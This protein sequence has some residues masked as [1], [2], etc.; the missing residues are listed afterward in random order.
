MSSKSRK[1]R[2]RRGTRPPQQQEQ[3]SEPQAAVEKAAPERP[4]RRRAPDERPPAPW[5]SFPLVELAVLV[6]LVM[7]I[8]GFFV[9]GTR[10]TT[11]IAVGLA[12]AS[13]AGLELSVR[14]H[15]AGYRSHSLLLAGTVAV[16]TVSVCY[17]LLGLVLGAGLVA[18]ALVF[19]A[20]V[21]YLRGAFRRASGGLSFR[22]GGLRG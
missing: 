2:K 6:G 15:F 17:F 12:L 13:L 4:R 20:A 19:A 22:V 5:G 9:Q 8:G 18:G 11:M 3:R 10:G 16:A 7:L 21:Y 14:E 1:R